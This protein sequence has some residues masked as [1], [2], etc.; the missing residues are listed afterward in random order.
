MTSSLH[1]ELRRA[2]ELGPSGRGRRAREM[3]RLSLSEVAVAIGVD[4]ATLCRWER[5]LVRPRRA[6]ALRWLS[7]VDD[8]QSADIPSRSERYVES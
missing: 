7:V 6:A 8:L 1:I 4:A 3:A 5:G 2:R